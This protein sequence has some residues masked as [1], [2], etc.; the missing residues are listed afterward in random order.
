MLLCI[1]IF[2]SDISCTEAF[3]IASHIESSISLN[4]S[5]DI[6]S[7]CS[8]VSSTVILLSIVS[9]MLDLVKKDV[10]SFLGETIFLLIGRGISSFD[11][12]LIR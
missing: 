5:F 12:L 2:K 3:K 1:D 9:G 7:S 10:N 8:N 11:H 4:S 6:L